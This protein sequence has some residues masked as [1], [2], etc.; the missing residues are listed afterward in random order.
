MPTI[1]SGNNMKIPLMVFEV[2][3]LCQNRCKYCAH[4]GMI[5]EDPTYQ[6]P[7]EDVSAFIS[8]FQKIIC[9]IETIWITGPGEPLMWKYFNDAVRLLTDVGGYRVAVAT[10]GKSLHII[11]ENTWDRLSLLRISDY[12]YAINKSITS[13]HSKKIELF[14]RNMFEA[15]DYENIPVNSFVECLCHGPMYYKG[16]IYPYC[17]PVLFDACKLSKTNH[18]KYCMP[19]VEYS[20]ATSVGISHLTSLPCG[21]CFGNTKVTRREVNHEELK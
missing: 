9:G 17:G 16:R 13:K 14:P 12:G 11:D 7:L 5:E 3:S 21:W 19:L 2:C 6:M 20:P 4:N 15:I 8:H 10:N 18:M 1:R